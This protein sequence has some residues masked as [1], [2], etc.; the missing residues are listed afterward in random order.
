MLLAIEKM[1]GKNVFFHNAVSVFIVVDNIVH[2][3]TY[4]LYRYL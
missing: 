1:V 4:V 2:S 3:F